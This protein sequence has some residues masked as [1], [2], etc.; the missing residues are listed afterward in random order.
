MEHAKKV[1]LLVDLQSAA[2]DQ[3]II[4]SLSNLK[5][6]EYIVELWKKTISQEIGKMFGENHEELAGEMDSLRSTLGEI[7]KT[8]IMQLLLQFYS[9]YTN[10]PQATNTQP[11]AQQPAAQT[12]PQM[13][14][15]PPSRGGIYP[16]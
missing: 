16:Y 13:A 10:Q 14:M 9:K 12:A 15:N 5:N 1:G 6:G 2:D 4:E 3:F 7:S 8:P 11:I